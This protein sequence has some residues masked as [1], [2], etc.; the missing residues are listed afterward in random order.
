MRA[1]LE[2]LL[3]HP[4]ITQRYFYPRQDAPPE[5]SAMTVVGAQGV[6]LRCAR[7]EHDASWLWLV[8]FHGNGEVVADYLPGFIELTRQLRVNVVLAEYRGYGGSQGTPQLGAMLEDVA[9]IAQAAA[10]PQ[11][12]VA[13]GRSI[14]S[15]YALE[16]AARQPQ[17][18][19][20][21][22]ES[23]IASVLERVLLRASPQELG[24]SMQALEREAA[25]LVD[26]EAKLG[27]YTG[28]LLL[29][30]ARWDHLVDVEHARQNLAWSA[31]QDKTLVELPRGDHNS[32]FASNAQAYTQALDD[33][34]RRC[35]ARAWT[36]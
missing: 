18:A 15:I 12:V 20:L 25:R 17:L 34:L 22:L 29:L 35:E 5:G 9:A 19:G 21:V 36:R 2:S 16:L 30:H 3:D 23:G 6:A 24:C 26:H 13:F 11:R 14:G 28:P 4:L 31:S 27:A 10:P 7:V 1:P 32:V 33:F 8:H